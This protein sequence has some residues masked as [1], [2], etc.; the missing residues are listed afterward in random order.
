MVAKWF[1]YYKCK[2]DEQ[3]GSITNTDAVKIS[4]CLPVET[5]I[6]VIKELITHIN[7]KKSTTFLHINNNPKRRSAVVT[8]AN[9]VKQK[10]NQ[11]S[12]GRSK[13]RQQRRK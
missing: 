9:I 1:Q 3:G 10:R 5:A 11:K 6:K 8:D 12:R 7:H 13:K 4:M 2:Y